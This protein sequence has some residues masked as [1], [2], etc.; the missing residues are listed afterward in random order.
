MSNSPAFIGLG[1]MRCGSTWIARILEEHPDIYI[2]T[3]FKEVHFF[4]TFYQNPKVRDERRRWNYEKG[5]AWYESMFG[6]ARSQQIFGEITPNYLYDEQ[7]PH[8]IKQHYPN[9]KFIVSLRDPVQRAISHMNYVNLN[10]MGAQEQVGMEFLNRFNDSYGFTEFSKYSKYLNRYFEVF[11]RSQFLIISYN[12]METKPL[13]V[14]KRIYAFL[15][16]DDVF[17]PPSLNQKINTSS[18][19]K[20]R[21]LFAFLRK[22]RKALKRH[23]YL[24]NVLKKMGLVAVYRHLT[25]MNTHSLSERNE[26]HD[27]KEFLKN[28][29]EEE[30]IF[31]NDLFSYG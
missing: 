27:L 20:F 23:R 26:D 21:I 2:P 6:E 10:Q 31:L 17:E 29:F 30:R 11:D 28:E 1:A 3:A 15:D 25:H 16:V 9:I 18:G 5:I 8:L 13:E 7:A 12:E 19:K 14:S 22:L 24:V 4:D